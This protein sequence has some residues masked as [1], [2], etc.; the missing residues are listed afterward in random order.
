MTLVFVFYLP[1]AIKLSCSW[2]MS[3]AN[4]KLLEEVIANQIAAGEVVERPASVVKELVEN[5]IDAGASQVTVEIK[6]GGQAMIRVVDNGRGMTP[7]DLD[8][9]ILR[10]ATSKLVHLEDLD[11]LETLGFRGEAIPSI[12]S[13]SRMAIRSRTQD[14]LG[15]TRLTVEGGREKTVVE[16]PGP[17]GTEIRVEDLFFNVPARRKF[18]KKAATEASHIHEW[19]QR[20]AICYPRIALRFIKEG[21]TICDYPPTDSLKHRIGD[22]FGR[23]YLDQIREV[24]VPGAMGLNGFVGHPSLARGTARH[25]HIFINGRYVRDRVIM[26]AIQQAYGTALPKGRHPFV[27]LMLRLPALLV[28]VNVHPAKTEVR[29]SDSRAVHRLVARSINAVIRQQDGFAANV[30]PGPGPD[31]KPLH[32]DTPLSPPNVSESVVRSRGVSDHRDRVLAAMERMAQKRGGTPGRKDASRDQSMRRPLPV[33]LGLSPANELTESEPEKSRGVSSE[34]EYFDRL[35]PST[36]PALRFVALFENYAFFIESDS[37][38]VVDRMGFLEAQLY[39]ALSGD[40]RPEP[41]DRPV[42]VQIP[43]GLEPGSD[44]FRRLAIGIEAI[45]TNDFI[46]VERPTILST[47]S[48]LKWLQWWDASAGQPTETNGLT[49]LVEL[50]AEVAWSRVKSIEI[51]DRL[52]TLAGVE[53]PAW[54]RRLN[55]AD[56]KRLLW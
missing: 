50:E 41:L 49:R 35:A 36:P 22:V 54:L 27:V 33:Q 6:D 34:P 56:I 9:C 16:C 11:T 40:V 29:F 55:S 45:G 26:A 3:L 10:H 52:S 1:N 53:D 8:M 28:D 5:S 18:L 21:K 24:L 12:A 44:L 17:V 30:A 13:V 37:L 43:A 39:L 48:I 19:L 32:L 4:I 31:V 38:L 20:L 51:V 23:Q 14:A 7:V 25:Y 46:L 42:A 2:G 47:E 15:A